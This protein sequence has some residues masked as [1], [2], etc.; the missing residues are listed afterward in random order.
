M[1]HLLDCCVYV[2]SQRYIS[3]KIR[4]VPFFSKRWNNFDGLLLKSSGDV[5]ETPQLLPED[6]LMEILAKLPTKSLRR[7][8]CVSKQWRDLIST[9]SPALDLPYETELSLI[10]RSSCN[11]IVCFMDGDPRWGKQ[12]GFY[13]CNPVTRDYLRLPTSTAFPENYPYRREAFGFGIDS[14]SAPGGNN[15]KVVRIVGLFENP[16][17]HMMG[18]SSKRYAEIYRVATNSWSEIEYNIRGND[19]R[20]KLSYFHGGHQG[21]VVNG[22]CHWQV[23]ATKRRFEE[24]IPI[25]TFDF[26]REIFGRMEALAPSCDPNFHYLRTP[27]QLTV[28]HDSLAIFLHV[29][30]RQEADDDESSDDESYVERKFD[31]YVDVWVMREYGNDESWTKIY[32]VLRITTDSP[33]SQLWGNLC[34]WNDEELVALHT[35]RNLV[36]CSLAHQLHHQQEDKQ[37]HTRAVRNMDPQLFYYGAATTIS[38]RPT[39]ISLGGRS[40]TIAPRNVDKFLST[41]KSVAVEAEP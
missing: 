12:L 29:C 7:F 14:S 20:M 37:P 22:C 34:F 21:V 35:D 8:L 10:Q 33:K 6:V 16:K 26:Q 1:D 13:L 9:V 28:L 17:E 38:F 30:K 4:F 11:G 25:V 2:L 24:R 40:S 41:A 36:S 5:S 32:S 31:N 19:K 15:Y 23:R 39:L 27:T 3:S 18:K